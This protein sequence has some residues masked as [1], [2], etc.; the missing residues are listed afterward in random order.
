MHTHSPPL[1]QQYKS[2]GYNN[3][4]SIFSPYSNNFK[5][6]MLNYVE[7]SKVSGHELGKLF[8]CLKSDK[9]VTTFLKILQ[10]IKLCKMFLCK[11]QGSKTKYL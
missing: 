8:L 2:L 11:L 3:G 6:Y 10:E 5:I 4:K 1:T 9:L 7:P